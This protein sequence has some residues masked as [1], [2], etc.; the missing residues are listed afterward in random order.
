MFCVRE[1]KKKK[2]QHVQQN[3]NQ[4]VLNVELVLLLLQGYGT[5]VHPGTRLLTNSA[6]TS[7][8]G[9]PTS[10]GLEKRTQT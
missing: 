2:N 6:A 4:N 7:A 1:F 10:L 3:V 8:F 9:R 5:T